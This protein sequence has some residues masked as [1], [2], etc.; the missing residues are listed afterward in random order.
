MGD[1]AGGR[2]GGHQD[3]TGMLTESRRRTC[4]TPCSSIGRHITHNG[5]YGYDESGIIDFVVLGLGLYVDDI[6]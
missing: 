5:M 3:G 2:I 4:L 6:G 1:C